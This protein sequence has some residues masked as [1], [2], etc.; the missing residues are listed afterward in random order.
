MTAKNKATVKKT[1]N[2]P[3]KNKVAEHP[4]KGDSKRYVKTV[5]GG[6]AS[7]P[8]GNSVSSAK[9]KSKNAKKSGSAGNAK[10]TKISKPVKTVKVEPVDSRKTVYLLAGGEREPAVNQRYWASFV[11][12]EGLLNKAF[13]SVG[14]SLV[15]AHPYKPSEKHGFV[16]SQKEGLDLFSNLDPE[17]PVLVVESTCRYSNHLLPGL[18]LHRGPILTC[19]RW[20]G[21]TPSIAG[22]LNLNDGLGKAGKPFSSLWSVDFSDKWFL[23]RL[24]K[25]LKTGVLKHS[26]SHLTALKRQAVT[27]TNRILGEKLAAEL[28]AGK[29]ILGVFH[30]GDTGTYNTILPDE[31]LFGL[32]IF[33]ER[34]SLAELYY[35]AGRITD[36]EARDVYRWIMAKGMTFHLGENEETDL[37]LRQILPQ[38]KV[39][40]AVL[41]LADRYGCTAIGIQ[42]VQ[43]LKYLLPAVDLAEGILGNTERPPIKAPGS[44]RYFFEGRPFLHFYA[45]DEPAALDA[46][47]TR[48]VAAALE[49]PLETTQMQIRWGDTDPTETVDG[50]VW[51]FQ[52]AAVPPAWFEG[53]WKAAES[54]RR[55]IDF[56][57]LGGGTLRGVCRRGEIVWSRIFV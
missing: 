3:T 57:P 43:G 13:K 52:S 34:L 6:K 29:A 53:G 16:A 42:G 48:R 46:L 45:G 20:I 23:E 14:F 11:E 21:K 5:S 27:S 12:M 7:L 50:F 38:C 26:T 56:F 1:A 47:L 8:T 44:S 2:S 39:Y 37:T 54:V 25:W 31:S 19:A 51:T 28:R 22:M 10:Y 9:N 33:K 15:R 36:E 24:E 35:E 30:D 18:L 49:Q 40:I 41:R 32:G 55:P 4:T 17:A